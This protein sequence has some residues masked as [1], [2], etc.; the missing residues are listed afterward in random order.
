MSRATRRDAYACVGRNVLIC[1][2]YSLS[3]YGCNK[4]ERQW[5]EV[6]SLYGTDMT[7]V[8]SGGLVYE[9]S[10]EGS[11]YGIV[12][13][14]GNTVTE[15]TDYAPLKAAFSNT[16]SPSGD[17][18][19]K[20]DLPPQPCPA[21]VPGAWESDDNLP[22]MPEPAK[23]YMQEGAGTPPG[24]N[25]DGSQNHGTPSSSTASPGVS[26]G[27]SGSAGSASSTAAA[28]SL[29]VPELSAAPLVCGAI[30]VI[31]M[32]VGASLL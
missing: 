25:G 8:Y 32:L 15:D 23:K 26:N 27:V 12:T 5:Q 29:R 4:G 19:Y 21:V 16:P 18:G 10:E 2:A 31:G 24:L 7:P 20:T 14:T 30:S 22:A 6:A 28:A 13:I 11:N 3:E 1:L 9:Y 17:G